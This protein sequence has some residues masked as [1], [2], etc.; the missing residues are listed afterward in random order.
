MRC[1]YC[2]GGDGDGA[3]IELYYV[4]VCVGS[5]GCLDV[6]CDSVRGLGSIVGWLFWLNLCAML[7]VIQEWEVP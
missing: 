3:D 4:L 1:L 6:T 5:L 7:Y 2:A